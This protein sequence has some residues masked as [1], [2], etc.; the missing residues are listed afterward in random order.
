MKAINANANS[1]LEELHLDNITVKKNFIALLE[2]FM[3]NKP[4]FKL[5]YG[6][7]THNSSKRGSLASSH[8]NDDNDP[9]RR[10]KNDLL[11][12]LK[13]FLL[14]KRLRA[15]DLFNCLD[16]DKTQSVSPDEMFI[17]LKKLNV[18]LTDL[19]LK[20]LIRILDKDGDGEIDYGE[21]AAV[22]DI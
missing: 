15:V 16:K 22:N 10:V 8:G 5:T 4:A 6:T 21:F 11:T 18:P 3:K 17:G 19:Q 14:E 2:E 13:T 7:S 1:A 9:V 12:A 20:K